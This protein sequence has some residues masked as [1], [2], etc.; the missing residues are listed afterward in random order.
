MSSPAFQIRRATVDDLPRLLELWQG[1]AFPLKE[2]DLEKR[3]TEFQ[4]AVDNE[5][6]VLGAIGLDVAGA[7]GRIHHEAFDDFGLAADLRPLFWERILMLAQNS[8]VFRLWTQETAPFWKQCGL[9]PAD[10]PTLQKLPGKW[11]SAAADWH[12][13]QLKDE[14]AFQAAAWDQEFAAMIRAERERVAARVEFFKKAGLITA[15]LFAMLVA[16]MLLYLFRRDP[17]ILQNISNSLKP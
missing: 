3:L 7:Q 1:M 6:N 16:V 10:K 9:Q 14:S 15:I 11:I 13:L 12:T 4:V 8:G 5:G 2:L 17:T